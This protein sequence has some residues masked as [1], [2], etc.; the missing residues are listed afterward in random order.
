MSQPRPCRPRQHSPCCNQVIVRYDW[1]R[2]WAG[3]C[4]G[5]WWRVI[6][7]NLIKKVFREETCLKFQTGVV[8]T[9][10]A[11]PYDPL[12]HQSDCRTLHHPPL[13]R[14]L[15]LWCSQGWGLSLA[16][17]PS[18]PRWSSFSCCRREVWTEGD[19]RGAKSDGG[20]QVVVEVLQ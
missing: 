5:G 18:S 13:P 10:G 4:E 2:W 14:G 8:L 19:G 20:L 6:L 15:P 17:L 9:W 11:W 1:S 7:I 3:H 16:S 12:L